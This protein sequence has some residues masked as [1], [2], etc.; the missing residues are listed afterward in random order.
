[1]PKRATLSG[2][3]LSPKGRYSDPQ[4]ERGGFRAALDAFS[5]NAVPHMGSLP[6]SMQRSSTAVPAS[7]I[8]VL[9]QPQPGTVPTKYSA[10]RRIKDLASVLVTLLLALSNV[11]GNTVRV[12]GHCGV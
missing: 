4:E 5:R 11:L 6:G 10:S 8:F 1:V 9:H 3:G 2:N 7:F 12:F